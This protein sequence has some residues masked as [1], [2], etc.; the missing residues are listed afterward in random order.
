MRRLKNLGTKRNR[1]AHCKIAFDDE[2]YMFMDDNFDQ[3][4]S[5]MLTWEKFTRKEVIDLAKAITSLN[6][7]L[8]RFGAENAAHVLK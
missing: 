8:I 5:L 2:H 1:L 4:G 7:D 6:G 3:D